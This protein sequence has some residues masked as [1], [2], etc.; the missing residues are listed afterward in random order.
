MSNFLFKNP[1]I[2][3][4][5]IQKIKGGRFLGHGVHAINLTI[6][7]GERKLKNGNK[8]YLLGNQE[9]RKF[10]ASAHA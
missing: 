5:V 4:R 1:L 7:G 2:F 8:V 6:F 3:D 10:P 9:A